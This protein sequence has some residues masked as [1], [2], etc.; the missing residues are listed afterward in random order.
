MDI[1]N[2]PKL[3]LSCNY[4]NKDSFTYNDSYLYLHKGSRPYHFRTGNNLLTTISTEVNNNVHNVDFFDTQFFKDHQSSVIND[5]VIYID[6]LCNFPR[7]VIKQVKDK[8]KFTK[9][10]EDATICVIPHDRTRL[11]SN[12]LFVFYKEGCE[13]ILCFDKY[14][15]IDSPDLGESF[16]DWHNKNLK[17]VKE[18]NLERPENKSFLEAFK[19]AKCIF[20]DY[21]VNVERNYEHIIKILNGTYPKVIIEYDFVK[22]IALPENVITGDMAVSLF[23]LLTSNDKET[24]V[25]GLKLLANLNF[26]NYKT[27]TSFLLKHISDP[28]LLK[29]NNRDIKFLFKYFTNN[30]YSDFA[31]AEDH[32]LEVIKTLT[33]YYINKELTKVV[34]DM[35][36]GS[37][38]S[39]NTDLTI[40]FND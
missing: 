22:E 5:D 12:R 28:K 7:S 6:P 38:I 18:E 35:F 23:D 15:N 21:V 11:I 40:T 14:Y 8:Y 39:A 1:I 19:D 29:T 16:L 27:V 2:A 24:I 32:E 20:N 4:F 30:K 34:T 17:R 36:K 26:I 25:S 10:P 31:H 3:W 33:P 37:K 9:S 13:E